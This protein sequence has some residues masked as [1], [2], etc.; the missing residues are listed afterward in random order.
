MKLDSTVFNTSINRRTFL[1]LAGALSL[2]AAALGTP[3]LSETV[4]FNRRLHKVSSSRLAMGTFVNIVIFHPSQLEA[5]EATEY[6]FDAICRLSDLMSRFQSNS[7]ISHLNERG[8][9][10]DVPPEILDVLEASARYHRVSGG[11]FDITVKPLVDLYQ[12]SFRKNGNP[13]ST[14]S[15]QAALDRVGSR[16]LALSQREVSFG[17]DGIEITLDGIAKG[18]IVDQAMAVLRSRGVQHALINAGGD[19]AVCGGK[20]DGK[21]WRIAVQD[22]WKRDRYRDVI[23]LKNGAV[24]TSGS[25]EVYFDEEKLFH[26]LLSPSSGFPVSHSASVSIV[27]SHAME[28]DALSTAVFVMGPERG[29]RFINRMPGTDGFIIDNEGDE[30]LSEKWKRNNV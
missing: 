7:P 28:A 27:A 12:E 6:A 26:H 13:P 19:I 9:L 18:Y 11:A 22:P 16:H 10:N 29:S 17:R 8:R 14:Q 21:P 25:Y 5:E 15:M 3:V 30:I 20:E 4:K 24:A 2:N 23:T 1:A